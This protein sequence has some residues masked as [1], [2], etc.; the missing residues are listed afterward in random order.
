MTPDAVSAARL[1][2]DAAAL[3]ARRPTALLGAAALGW[4]PLFIA[5]LAFLS[6]VEAAAEPPLLE[7]L[8]LG[9]LAVGAWMTS[10]WSSAAAVRLCAAELDGGH[11]SLGAALRR[12]AADVPRVLIAST[13]RA[14][15]T[16]LGALPL[17]A[18]LAHARVLTGGLVPSTVLDAQGLR[19][20]WQL[21]ARS[22]RAFAAVHLMSWAAWLLAWGN[23]ALGGLALAQA[24]DPLRVIA[25]LQARDEQ[26]L[27]VAAG[28]LALLLV[29]PLRVGGLTVAWAEDR[30]RRLGSDLLR[31]AQESA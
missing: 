1:L 18:G 24:L 9:A 2:D 5:A 17:G 21:S 29:E 19:V 16:A 10:C 11:L 8:A 12:A 30:R 31:Q 14:L 25:P 20:G 28:L 23:L 15:V 26:V 13:A 4:L 27:L 3:V 6:L 22:A 7:L